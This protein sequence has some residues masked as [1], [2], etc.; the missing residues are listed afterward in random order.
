MTTAVAPRGDNYGSGILVQ[1][2]PGVQV[3]PT[4]IS[5]EESVGFNEVEQI[6]ELIVAEVN[7]SAWMMGDWLN[8]LRRYRQH[9]P[10]GVEK[11]ELRYKTLRNLAYVAGKVAEANRFEQLS[12]SHHRAVAPLQPDAQRLWLE[13][14]LR[15]GWTVVELEQELR[16]IRPASSSPAIAAAPPLDRWFDPERVQRW[17]EYAERHEMDVAQ[18]VTKAT[19]MYIQAELA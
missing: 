8:T 10:K 5:I 19:D 7:A 11:L 18:L 12:W 1:F 6:G 3:T 15:H 17:T 16:A 14:A 9:Y 13:D 2:G 4:G